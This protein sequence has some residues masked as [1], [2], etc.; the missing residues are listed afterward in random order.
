MSGGAFHNIAYES[1]PNHQPARIP[2]CN[3]HAHVRASPTLTYIK[4]LFQFIYYSHDAFTS[5]ALKLTKKTTF[6]LVSEGCFVI[7]FQKVLPALSFFLIMTPFF[8][9]NIL[10]GRHSPVGSVA[11]VRRTGLFAFYGRSLISSFVK[12]M[13]SPLFDV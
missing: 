6:T 7:F 9:K 11:F 1:T 4:H 5:F 12:F 8:L 3:L 2:K 10:I 13:F